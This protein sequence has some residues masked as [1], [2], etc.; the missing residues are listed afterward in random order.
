MEL[1]RER[2][3]KRTRGGRKEVLLR[4]QKGKERKGYGR[5][6]KDT[7]PNVFL[8]L[9]PLMRVRQATDVLRLLGRPV[10]QTYPVG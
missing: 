1:Y 2:W 6:I 10:E 4:I 8:E 7:S 3:E 9:D 5:R